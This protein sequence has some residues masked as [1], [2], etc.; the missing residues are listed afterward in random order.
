MLVIRGGGT[1]G[2]GFVALSKESFPLLGVAGNLPALSAKLEGWHPGGATPALEEA[3]VQTRDVWGAQFGEGVAKVVERRMIEAGESGP[4]NVS[5][6]AEADK[7]TVYHEGVVR[8]VLRWIGVLALCSAIA[9]LGRLATSPA[10]SAPGSLASKIE[11][12]PA[13]PGRFAFPSAASQVHFDSS[14]LPNN[15]PLDAPSKEV[16][17]SDILATAV[18]EV[19]GDDSKKKKRRQKRKGKKGDDDGG[20]PDDDDDEHAVETPVLPSTTFVSAQTTPRLPPSES[21]PTLGPAMPTSLIPSTSDALTISDTLLGT[22]SHGTLV[23]KG[24]FQS[25]P[26]AVKRLLSHFTSLHEREITLLQSSDH[27]PNIIRYFYQEHREPWLLIALELCPCSLSELVERGPKGDAAIWD[28][29]RDR[30]EEVMMGAVQGVEHLH[31]LKICHRDI[32]PQNIL[33]TV[34]KSGRIRLLISDFGLAKQQTLDQSS[35]GATLYSA[36]TTGHLPTGSPG[37][38]APE[39]LMDGSE[40]DEGGGDWE[41]VGA[42]EGSGSGSGGG[43]LAR[44][45]RLSRKV[46]V[47]ALGCVIGWALSGGLHPL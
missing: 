31:S 2:R 41:V 12:S 5:G 47:F 38:R 8:R 37:W 9:Y 35:F 16:T 27:H 17:T 14:L 15:S 43:K 42:A 22:G 7:V 6:E 21:F 29:W 26:V 34:T 40:G 3:A 44:S 39:L 13:P 19:V 11:Q 20:A 28:Q 24:S 18:P 45:A 36:S 32:K 10:S 30:K 25:R 33:V 23:F 46:D 1:M 4:S